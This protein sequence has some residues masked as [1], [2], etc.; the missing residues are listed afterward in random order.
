MR[1]LMTANPA[2]FPLAVHEGTP[3]LWHLATVLSWLRDSQHRK[4]DVELLEVA[5]ANMT[6][7]IAREARRLP[8]ALLP[9]SLAPLFA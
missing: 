3:S 5:T 8:G 9:K 7:N 1:K 4:V 2:T 6:L